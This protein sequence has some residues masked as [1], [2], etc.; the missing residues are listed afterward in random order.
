MGAVIRR[1]EA[2]RH[3]KMLGSAGGHVREMKEGNREGEGHRAI[4]LNVGNDDAS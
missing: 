2:S 3:Q 1:E 4:C